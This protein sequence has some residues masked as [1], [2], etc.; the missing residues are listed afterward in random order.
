MASEESFLVLVHYR[1]SIKKKTRFGI[2]FNDK[3]PFSI[4]LKPT[5]S[6]PMFLNS[7]IQKLGL[8][9]VKWVEKL[10][11][12]ILISVLRD[13]VKYDL[14]VIGSDEDLE[15][16]FHCRRQFPEVK[17]PELLTKLVD[18]V[19]NSGGS[20]QN[21][22]TPA[23]VACS[24]L[25]PVGASLTVPVIAPQQG[26]LDGIDDALTDDDDIND[27]EPYI[28]SDDSND[29]IAASNPAGAG[30]ASSS[31]TQ[32]YLP[33]F[34]SLDLDAMRQEGVPGKPIEDKDETVLSVKTYSIQL[35]I[36]YKVVESDYRKYLGKC[37]EFGNGC[38]WLIRISLR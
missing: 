19:S 3:D 30:T 16:L 28:I 7:I 1:R 29:D 8:E 24:N 31:G 36:Q 21:I 18:V 25:R 34:S 26:T 9:G 6:F 4:F 14:F 10:L 13:D 22:Q 27:V 23:T 37:N 35:R 20:N 2:K 15:V 12:H 33:H 5:T 32:Q 17:T 11:Y 38:T